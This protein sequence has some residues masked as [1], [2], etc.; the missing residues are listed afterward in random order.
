MY[1]QD[2]GKVLDVSP[3]TPFKFISLRILKKLKESWLRAHEISHTSI[4]TNNNYTL[5]NV[6]TK[7][8]LPQR[9]K[10]SLP[11]ESTKLEITKNKKTTTVK[12]KKAG[13]HI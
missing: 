1:L 9:E 10:I 12:D 11:N 7:T 13:E 4:L 2:V 6:M 3:S 8:F 5:L